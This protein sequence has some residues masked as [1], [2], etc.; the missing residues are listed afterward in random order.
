MPPVR[1]F[2]V[3]KWAGG[4]RW[5]TP[6]LLELIGEGRRTLI[7]PFVG[8]GALF[9]AYQ[10]QRAILADTNSDLI[11]LYS[12]IRNSAT[13]LIARLTSYENSAEAFYRIRAMD[14]IN[15]LDRA[16]R[17]LY[18]CR[19]SFNG[20]YR[21]NSDGKYNVPY[22]YKTHRN[23]FDI[24]ALL[25]AESALQ[26][27]TLLCQDFEETMRTASYGDI[28]YADPPY[29]VAHNQNGFI[30]YN[31]IMFS[32][33][34]QERLAKC[35]RDAAA[36][37]ARVLVSNADHD[38]V[39]CLY[40]GCLIHVVERHSVVGAKSAYRKCVTELLIEVAR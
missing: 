24:S 19:N 1:K 22:G 20:I 31:R 40:D 33:Q 23:D 32:Y 18:L 37:G 16:A 34:D 39:R 28:V 7:E 11:N 6:R 30:K 5:L 14:P 26:S 3:L 2:P 29:T 13:Q 9:F 12:V 17:T 25:A 36:R 21:V 10:P 4:K 15:D 38:S 35:A 27:A 8:G